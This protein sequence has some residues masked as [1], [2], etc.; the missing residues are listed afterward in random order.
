[1]DSEILTAKT[2]SPP[3]MRRNEELCRWQSLLVRVRVACSFSPRPLLIVM[4][5]GISFHSAIDDNLNRLSRY[6]VFL[7]CSRG[8]ACKIWIK[9]MKE[10]VQIG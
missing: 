3:N 5:A 8:T 10:V 6:P 9:Q 4:I 7:V 2:N 1:M